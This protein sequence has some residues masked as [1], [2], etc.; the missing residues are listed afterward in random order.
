MMDTLR[1][2]GRFRRMSDQNNP[3][4]FNYPEFLGNRKLHG[5]VP[6][7]CLSIL[8][9]GALSMYGAPSDY[10]LTMAVL[11]VLLTLGAVTLSQC[12]RS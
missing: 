8:T 5:I 10:F 1:L 11:V 2:A 6:A 7:A 4:I 12:R 9:L 3:E